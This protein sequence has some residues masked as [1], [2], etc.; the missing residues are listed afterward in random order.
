[1]K[2]SFS[3]VRMD[4]NNPK[5]KDAIKREV[6]IYGRNNDFRSDFERDY[7]RIIYS[8]AYKR[9]KHKT[10]GLPP[11]KTQNSSFLHSSQ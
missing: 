2:D 11:L 3:K 1:M 5:W 8:N 9:L 4:E 10:Q 6:Q 7:T